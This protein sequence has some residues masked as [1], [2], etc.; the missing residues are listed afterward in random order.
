MRRCC[1]NTWITISRDRRF[2]QRGGF[3][4]R[5][6]RFDFL[7]VP[8]DNIIEYVQTNQE[9]LE[10]FVTGLM[11]DPPGDTAYN[12]WQISCY[13]AVGM[14]EFITKGTGVGS[15]T[16]YEGFYYSE[17]DRP[18]GFQGTKAGFVP[19]NTGWSWEEEKGDNRKR[20]EKIT[21]HWYWFQMNF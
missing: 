5:F 17:D 7:Y 8:K 4:A 15:S 1:R 18:I 9:T 20:T 16:A 13:P 21:A 2:A 12:G 14:V 3:Y 11:A 10:Q 19:D 6:Y